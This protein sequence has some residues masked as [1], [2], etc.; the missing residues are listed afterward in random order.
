M[1]FSNSNTK[2]PEVFQMKMRIDK[3]IKDLFA[4]PVVDLKMW[5][6]AKEDRQKIRTGCERFIQRQRSGSN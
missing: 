5:K 4:L 3:I 6:E 2:I 1:A